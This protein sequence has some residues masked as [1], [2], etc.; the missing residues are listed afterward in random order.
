MK[1]LY[2]TITGINH[3]YGTDVFREHRKVLLEKDRK[4]EFDKEAIK[5]TLEGLGTVGYV[6]NSPH[7]VLGDCVSAGRLYD[8]FRKK[9]KGRVVYV[10]ERG[11]VCRLEK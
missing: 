3:Y 1:K 10:T 4:N 6:A 2:F 9:G 7:T 8:C 11:I 5:V